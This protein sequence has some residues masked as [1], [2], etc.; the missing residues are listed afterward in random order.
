MI[1]IRISILVVVALAAHS[2][3]SEQAKL[4]VKKHPSYQ[5]YN[6]ER[7]DALKLSDFKQL[8]LAANGYSSDSIEWTGLM[9]TNSMASP[10][11]TLL[12]LVD[13]QKSGLISGKSFSVE[14][15]SSADFSYL[16]K[17]SLIQ[18]FTALPAQEELKSLDCSKDSAIYVFKLSDES[19]DLNARINSLIESVGKNCGENVDDLLA[20]VLATSAEASDESREVCIALL[21]KKFYLHAYLT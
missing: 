5:V 21:N 7:T 8:L 11:M 2:F 15:D 4:I 20:Y 19:G 1:D 3:A 6:Y 17:F 9:S 13:T 16:K 14:E 12:F 18:T 10:K